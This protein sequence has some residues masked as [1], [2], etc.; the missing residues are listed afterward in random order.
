MTSEQITT[1][2]VIIA[3]FIIGYLLITILMLVEKIKVYKSKMKMAKETIETSIK[4]LNGDIEILEVIEG[5]L[6]SVISNNF[7]PAQKSFIEI[8]RK[9]LGY[10]KD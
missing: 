2:W 3:I 6:N 4:I 9:V 8:C 10:L 7:I 5:K 1:A